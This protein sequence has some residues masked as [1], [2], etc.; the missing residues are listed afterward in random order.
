[1]YALA[2]C[3]ALLTLQDAPAGFKVELQYKDQGSWKAKSGA[4]AIPGIPLG[5]RITALDAEGAT[6]VTFNGE[7]PVAG[8]ARGKESVRSATFKNGEA[9]IKDVSVGDGAIVVGEGGAKS[10]LA[11]YRISGWLVILPPL[12]AVILAVVTREVIISLL[13]GVWI[14][15][16]FITGL[17]PWEATLRTLDTFLVNEVTEASHVKILFFTLALGGMVGILTRSGGTRG[18]AEAIAKVA[19]TRVSA[20]IASWVMGILIFFDDYANCL[21]VGSVSRPFTDKMRISREKLS[22]IVDATAAPVAT[23]GLVSTWIGYQIS[24]LASSGITTEKE[25]YGFFLQMIPYSFYSLFC[26]GLGFLVATMKR[27]FGPMYHAERRAFTTGQVLREGAAP[28]LGREIT[29]LEAGADVRPRWYNAAVPVFAVVAVTLVG[30]YFSGKDETH[31]GLREI[32]SNANSFNVLVWASVAGGVVAILMAWV[33]RQLSLAKAVEAYV[34]GCKAMMLAV[35]ILVLAWSIG[36]VCQDLDAG[37]FV[38]SFVKGESVLKLLPLITF[39]VACAIAFATGTSWGTMAILIPV[40]A[41]IVVDAPEGAVNAA[42]TM[43][44]VLTGAIF[45]DHCSPISDTTI[46]ASMGSASDH[47]DH[48][49]TQLPYAALAAAVSAIGFVAVGY[50]VPWYA[51]VPAGL[52]FIAAFLRIVGRDPAASL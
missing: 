36:Q 5:V 21:I 42:A 2:L 45:G 17:H 20:Q 32:F 51:V 6:L 13:A 37:P 40:V 23:I 49:R 47:I 48:V 33:Q 4:V 34:A 38:A 46:L 11:V 43:A 16:L 14:G 29:D 22:F 9:L 27:D 24:L 18:L 41:P 25:G 7:V 50:G 52:I 30:L 10:E 1:M 39:L 15:V 19:R 12:V 28:L 8:L 44:A 31:T 35:I 26:L 3:A